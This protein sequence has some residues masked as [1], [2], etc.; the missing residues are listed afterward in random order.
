MG[1]SSKLVRVD[2]NLAKN[3]NTR[4]RVGRLQM[5]P[6]PI[7]DRCLVVGDCMRKHVFDNRFEVSST[8]SRGLPRRLVINL[9]PNISVIRNLEHAHV[10]QAGP[11]SNPLSGLLEENIAR[12]QRIQIRKHSIPETRGRTLQAPG[13][14]PTQSFP[15]VELEAQWGQGLL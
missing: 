2:I 7:P 13:P 15:R 1:L 3:Q 12:N 8:I 6:N 9:K 4:N 11:T 14:G 5:R 10:L